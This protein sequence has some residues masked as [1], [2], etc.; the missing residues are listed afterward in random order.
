ML[1]CYTAVL[2]VIVDLNLIVA[3]RPI[4]QYGKRK[5]KKRERSFLTVKEVYMLSR[6]LRGR[7]EWVEASDCT[8]PRLSSLV[9]VGRVSEGKLQPVGFSQ[10][11]AHFLVAP[12]HCGKV[13][14]EDHQALQGQK[15]NS[16]NEK[17]SDKESASEI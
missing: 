12:V 3:E 4:G 6:Q 11:Y 7:N 1:E 17:S 5:A 13:L 16:G 9:V 2:S 14:Q 10:Q 15:R 8:L